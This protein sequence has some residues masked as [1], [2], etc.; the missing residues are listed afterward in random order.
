MRVND[1]LPGIF[2]HTEQASPEAQKA[3]MLAEME[4]LSRY[5]AKKLRYYQ[6]WSDPVERAKLQEELGYVAVSAES[7]LENAKKLSA[8]MKHRDSLERF[9]RALAKAAFTITPF[10]KPQLSRWQRIRAWICATF[11]RR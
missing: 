4:Q 7:A 9:N 5:R 6:R 2:H 1:I 10:T 3:Q 8:A 11:L